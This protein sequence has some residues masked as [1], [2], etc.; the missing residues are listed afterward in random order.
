MKK[1]GILLL[2]A[3][4]AVCGLMTFAA[5]NEETPGPGDDPIVTPGPDEPGKPEEPDEPEE[6]TSPEEEPEATEGLVFELLTTENSVGFG[7]VLGADFEDCYVCTGLTVAEENV[8]IPSTYNG[9]PV[10]G[11]YEG[12][13][14]DMSSD[15]AKGIT[16][17]YFPDSIQ[18]VLVTDETFENLREIRLPR[19][20]NAVISFNDFF[21]GCAFYNDPSNWDNGALYMDDW[22][23]ATNGDLPEEYTV[24]Q[25]TYGIAFGA[26]VRQD[27][28]SAKNQVKKVTV[29]DSVQALYGS[30]VG[31][32]SL[33]EVVLPDSLSS[34]G[35]YAFLGCFSLESIIIP[36]S[37]TSIDYYAF[38]DCGLTNVTIPDSVTSIGYGAFSSC[39]SLRSVKIPD[40]VT[41][42]DRYAFSDCSS[43]SDITIPDG[44]T[45]FG[46]GAFS[47]CISL[48]SITIPDSVTSIGREAF[49]RCSSLMSVTIGDGVTSIGDN[50]FAWC[51]SLETVYYRGSEEEWNEIEISWGNDDLED[52]EIVFNYKG[53]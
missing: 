40:S 17:L 50:A 5:C 31:C 52:A 24:K 28:E 46:E 41:S 45:S 20:A 13:M 53:E 15:I 30:F 43:L 34:I 38:S 6:P 48:E 37:V 7:A 9:L 23:L 19:N 51:E 11:F 25:G 2:A 49:L 8:V 16:S 22:L 27:I 36:D 14:Y 29:P 32:V 3:A 18:F 12:W 10:H 33:E 39:D 26:F 35:Y 21:S 42:I 47:Y 4:F 1:L 44:V